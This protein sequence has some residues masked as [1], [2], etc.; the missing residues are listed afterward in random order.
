MS[1]PENPT[2]RFVEVQE[3]EARWEDL[4]PQERTILEAVNQKVAAAQTLDDVLNFVFETTKDICPCDRLSAAFLEEDGKRVVSRWTRALYE[5]V[6]LRDGFHQ[7]IEGSSL[8]QVFDSGQ[9]RIINDLEQYVREHPGSASSK[10]ILREGIRSS[11]TCPLV[12]EGRKVGF[13]FRSSRKPN[14]Y[15]DHLVRIHY[16]MAERLSQAV[17][18][19]RRI[20]QLAAANR[21]YMEVLGFVTHELNSPLASLVMD[22]RVLLGG[23]LGS[24][25][26][27]H[28]EKIQNMIRK[29]EYL[30]SLIA[31]YLNLAQIEQ[32]ELRARIR[33]G[34]R[35][36]EEVSRPIISI[37][38]P[39]FEAR[40]IAFSTEIPEDMPGVDCDPSQMRVVLT[41][42]LSN[43]VKYAN[44]GGKTHLQARKTGDALEVSV[45]NEG[46]GFDE[47]DRPLLFR[48]FSRLRAP[49][50][51]REKGTG[52]GL[53]NVWRIVQQHGGRI[54]AESERGKWARFSLRI[55]QPLFPNG[56]Q[57]EKGGE[58]PAESDPAEL[59]PAE[60]DPGESP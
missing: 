16:A 50:L 13:L 19:T 22:G 55:P 57:T 37:L 58:D 4:A 24:I 33:Q 10:L 18:K 6:L 15:N 46:P 39:Q 43:A 3:A 31:E 12:V 35:F 8:Q 7:D 60:S 47:A 51:L 38:L 59:G 14:A 29:A 40:N 41:N 34:V 1:T 48:K 53:Y 52:V 44:R 23:Y 36:A 20:E 17:E 5:P 21:A 45:W 11:M 27:R 26:P 32:G 25:E 9:A 2:V 42:L 56:E 28:Q 30:L 54:W 49:E